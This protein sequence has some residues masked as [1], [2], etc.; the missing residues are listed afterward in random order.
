[1]RVTV[2]AVNTV[3]M[4]PS[5]SVTAKPLIGPDPSANINRPA[6]NVVNWLSMIV[7]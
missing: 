3:V 6:M 5:V 1:M 2:K 4:M 7:A